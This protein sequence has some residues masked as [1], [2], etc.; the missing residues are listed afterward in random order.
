MSRK[1]TYYYYEIV[2]EFREVFQVRL[3]S[4][5]Y[6]SIFPVILIILSLSF[7][8]CDDCLLNQIRHT[9]H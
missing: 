1:F 4:F 9:E 3:L 2:N 6:V 7:V 5:E 8:H